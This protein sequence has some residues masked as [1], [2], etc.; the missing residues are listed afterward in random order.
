MPGLGIGYGGKGTGYGMGFNPTGTVGGEFK[1]I[2]FD[3]TLG[4][5]G[6]GNGG[7]GNRR[8]DQPPQQDDKG[9]LT[10]LDRGAPGGG[11]TA[12]TAL[13][14]GGVAVGVVLLMNLLG[15]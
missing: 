12:R 9:P 2:E 8:Q 14:G 4:G 6:G 10:G 5:G 15:R 11:S 7:P 3:I 13:I 1:G